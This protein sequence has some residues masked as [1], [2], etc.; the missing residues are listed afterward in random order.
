MKGT[1]VFLRL[2][3]GKPI[4]IKGK[5]GAWSRSY[6]LGLIVLFPQTKVGSHLVN[7]TGWTGFRRF[8]DKHRFNIPVVLRDL[9]S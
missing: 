2:M 9:L 5:V 1:S 3:D 7:S 8:Q 4:N 6:S